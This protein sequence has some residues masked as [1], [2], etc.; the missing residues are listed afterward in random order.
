MCKTP[1]NSRYQTKYCS[2]QC[3][4]NERKQLII[5]KIENG[6]TKQ[7]H[8]QYRKYLF[9]KYGPKCMLCGWSEINPV[10]NLVP[11]EMDHI[12]GNSENNNLT[13]LRLICSNCS[14]LQPTYKSLNKGKGRFS[15][16]LRYK[17]GK[18]F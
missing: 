13:N 8:R 2:V 11:L 10:T 5:S 16:K 9:A 3:Q 7:D 4:A 14:S 1:L 17:S 6:D 15:R 18:S 12:D